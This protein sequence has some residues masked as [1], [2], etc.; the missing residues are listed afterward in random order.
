M[1]S[2]SKITQTLT[3]LTLFT[4]AITGGTIESP[5]F[6]DNFIKSTGDDCTNEDCIKRIDWNDFSQSIDL[7]NI[8]PYL[9]QDSKRNDV[10]QM[11]IFSG[12]GCH[13]QV[14]SYTNQK[15]MKLNNFPYRLNYMT[16]DIQAIPDIFTHLFVKNL[17]HKIKNAGLEPNARKLN[18]LFLF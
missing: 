16:W 3:F 15:C 8:I 13:S 4:I 7:S 10:T 11:D 6:F 12:C 9:N 5:D 18:M 14:S 1:I 17:N 2:Y